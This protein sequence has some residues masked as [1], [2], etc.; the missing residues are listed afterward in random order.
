MECRENKKINSQESPDGQ[1]QKQ[2]LTAQRIDSLVYPDH[3]VKSFHGPPY[4]L[5]G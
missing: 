5:R 3:P 2:N 1:D 4:V